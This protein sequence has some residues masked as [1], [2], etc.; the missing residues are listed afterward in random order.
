MATQVRY[1]DYGSRVRSKNSAEPFALING[2]GPVFG[3][4]SVSLN[5][6]GSKII[7]GSTNKLDA[8]KP[9]S[10]YI[11]DESGNIKIPNHLL[12][13]TDGIIAAIY[14]D[15]ELDKPESSNSEYMVI[16]TH[17]YTETSEI[18]NP[19][20]ISVIPN[21]TGS[22]F[23]DMLESDD[24]TIKTW[25][26]S[27]KQWDPSFNQATSV[28]L[29]FIDLSDTGNIKVYN[30]FNNSWPIGSQL[31]LESIYQFNGSESNSGVVLNSPSNFLL[32]GLKSGSSNI[33]LL[34][35]YLSQVECTNASLPKLTFEIIRLKSDMWSLKG[36]YY[37]SIY[38]GW[39]SE[40][41]DS[42][43]VIKANSDSSKKN[44]YN[45]RMLYTQ[46]QITGGKFTIN[47]IRDIL[48]VKESENIELLHQDT[49]VRHVNSGMNICSILGLDFSTSVGN[50]II[51]DI[52][53]S[54][55]P[56]ITQ[57]LLYNSGKTGISC[58]VFFDITIKKTKAS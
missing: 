22:N 36:R 20:I 46:G 35:T 18:E 26:E 41:D 47:N 10:A 6:E 48:G 24:I 12:I 28:I 11:S 16:A 39:L 25:Y 32:W 15:I 23:K 17:N 27:I 8:N 37:F 54:T 40:E 14:G 44:D 3:F 57:Y 9:K 1:F 30:P 4:D 52:V 7:I 51:S 45:T 21:N 42:V 58:E 55:D 29:A 19:S 33:P 13:N 56:L 31:G 38:T 5:A 34:Y 50:S 49:S 43:P 2:I 53:I